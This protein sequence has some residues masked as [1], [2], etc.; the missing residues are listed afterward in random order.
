MNPNTIQ[1][2]PEIQAMSRSLSSL[3][4]DENPRPTKRAALDIAQTLSE[5]T[6]TEQLVSK[7]RAIEQDM[8]GG[9]HVNSRKALAKFLV[10]NKLSNPQT[11]NDKH[12]QLCA[13]T[14]LE[15]VARADQHSDTAS[16]LVHSYI[17]PGEFG[18]FMQIAKA[19]TPPAR[20]NTR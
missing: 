13:W 16:S 1:S 7:C 19:A 4:T 2:A 8:P 6:P 17:Q 18:H 14:L 12:R 9:I 3:S 5:K 20:K 10:E 11:L 15:H